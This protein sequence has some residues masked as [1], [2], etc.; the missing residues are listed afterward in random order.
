MP[1]FTERATGQPVLQAVTFPQQSLDRQNF[2]AIIP[3]QSKRR[4]PKC[5][6]SPKSGLTQRVMD[7][8]NGERH[9]VVALDYQ[10]AATSALAECSFFW[11][12]ACS[13][14]RNRSAQSK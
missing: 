14:V 13:P 7:G 5:T 3:P 9:G 2:Q 8:S 10:G 4:I 6:E 11:K 1:P 12:F